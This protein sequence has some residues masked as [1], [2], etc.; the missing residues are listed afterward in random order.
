MIATIQA[1]LESR[2][3]WDE[4][5][6]ALRT[7]M[8]W[9]QRSHPISHLAAHWS[10]FIA[11]NGSDALVARPG[12]DPIPRAIGLSILLQGNDS[13][14]PRWVVRSTNISHKDPRI[15]NLSVLVAM[16]TQSAHLSG[17]EFELSRP[18]SID[19]LVEASAFPEIE[20]PLTRLRELLSD[21]RSIR[22]AAIHL[23]VNDQSPSNL[24][25]GTLL[26][27]YSWLRHG[28]DYSQCVGRVIRL[29][30]DTRTAASVA[31]SL[32]AI[33]C[34]A[35]TIPSS[36]QSRVSYHPYDNA[37]RELLIERVRDWPHGAEDIQEAKALPIIPLGQL[38]RNLADSLTSPFLGWLKRVQ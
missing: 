31:G 17:T 20:Q 6:R 35:R 2:V 26:G 12:T 30:G 16:A 34:G 25:Q 32:S 18:D 36:W 9:Y 23:G 28:T 1:V 4:F 38:G 33:Q 15:A 27:L 14:T 11:S 13:S 10:K 3:S 22:K 37:W 8:A 5:V 21:Q 24:I 7:R 19:R 29:G